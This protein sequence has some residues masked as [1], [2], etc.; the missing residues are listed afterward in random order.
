MN[1]QFKI[2]TI[3]KL[4]AWITSSVPEINIFEASF[5]PDKDTIYIEWLNT[6]LPYL[7]G[8]IKD[9]ISINR[10]TLWISQHTYDNSDEGT[11]KNMIKS[12][13]ASGWC[14]K[15]HKYEFLQYGERVDA[16]RLAIQ[17]S[18]GDDDGNIH[19]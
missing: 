14:Y 18:P 10:A 3:Q 16:K 1:T 2:I 12:H 4:K 17:L 13:V 6:I 9:K 5:I 15:I 19:T 8:L 7:F 11:V